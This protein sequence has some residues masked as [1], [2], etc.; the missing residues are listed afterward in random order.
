MAH[1]YFMEIRDEEN[2]N[3]SVL[4]LW[5]NGKDRIY[6]E[7]GQLDDEDAPYYTGFITLTTS[8][9]RA[10]IGELKRLL[11]EIEPEQIKPG[12]GKQLTIGN[13]SASLPSKVNW[14]K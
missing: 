12:E 6:L 1:K 8:D 11:N 2:D 3:D 14:S 5:V 7:V 9:T 4:K 13:V 10:L